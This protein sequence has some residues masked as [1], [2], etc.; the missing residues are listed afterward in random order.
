MTTIAGWLI[1]LR[2]DQCDAREGCGRS[3]SDPGAGPRT[4]PRRIL[5]ASAARPSAGL[6]QGRTPA[7]SEAACPA[8]LR[9]GPALLGRVRDRGDAARTRA[10]RRIGDTAAPPALPRRGGV[11]R[12]RDRL[13]PPNRARIPARRWVLHRRK[14]EPRPDPRPDGGRRDPDLLRAHRG[15]ERHRWGDRGDVGRTGALP[16]QD[17]DG[18]HVHPD[19]HGRE[20][21]GSEGGRPTFRDPDVRLRRGRRRHARVGRL[22]V[23]ERWVPDGRHRRPPARSG[24]GATVLLVLR[25]SRQAP[26][27]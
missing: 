26:P 21:Q 7:A 4:R 10:G 27:R 23:H 6:A 15:G 12:G 11:A 17:A 16:L 25:H 8:R 19:D 20:P 2:D 5:E 9:L 18:H 1:L 14:G 22:A 24:L 3:D 13:L